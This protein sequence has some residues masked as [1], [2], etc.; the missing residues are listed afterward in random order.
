LFPGGLAIRPA[1]ACSFFTVHWEF[2]YLEDEVVDN[3]QYR[4]GDHGITDGTDH[5]TAVLENGDW[6]LCHSDFK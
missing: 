3:V 5:V 4:A 2:T 6:K 1:D